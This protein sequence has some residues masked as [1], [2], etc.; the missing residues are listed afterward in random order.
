MRV[1]CLI[2]CVSQ[3]WGFEEIGGEKR[4]VR[5]VYF[6]STQGMVFEGRLVYD[7]GEPIYIS[8]EEV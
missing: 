5:R 8:S 2:G 4:Y 6:V 3:T 7:Y 1:V